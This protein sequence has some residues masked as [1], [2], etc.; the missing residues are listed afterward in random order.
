MVTKVLKDPTYF[1]GVDFVATTTRR[2]IV[3]T[4]APPRE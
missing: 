2:K 4:A 3:G 1:V